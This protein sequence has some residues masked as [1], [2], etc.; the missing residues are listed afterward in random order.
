VPAVEI[1]H[2][3]SVDPAA[4]WAFI[5][6]IDHWA[7]LL[8][9]YQRHELIDDRHSLWVVKGELGGLTR[10]AE[11]DVTI[12]EWVERDHIAFTLQGL[13]EPFTGSGAV[14]VLQGASELSPPHPGRRRLRAW[15]ARWLLGRVTMAA[16]ENARPC[17]D[18]A[19]CR[20][21]CRLEVQ[22]GGGSGPIMNLLLGPILEAVASD[23]ASRIVNRLEQGGT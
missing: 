2:P 8:S 18:N 22:A 3:T 6:N 10:L 15:I 11:F 13:D 23:T 4:A 17:V 14:H 5:S 7:P 19:R 21:R 1:E 20:L 12:T 9:G 16:P